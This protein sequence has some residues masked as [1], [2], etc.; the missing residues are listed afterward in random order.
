ML[1]RKEKRYR[2]YYERYYKVSFI[3]PASADAKEVRFWC[4]KFF[5]KIP[6]VDAPQKMR[7]PERWFDKI[8]DDENARWCQRPSKNQRLFCFKDLADATAFK[9]RWMD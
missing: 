9:L 3:L 7:R 2:E 5:G 4:I 1:H 6:L 8:Y